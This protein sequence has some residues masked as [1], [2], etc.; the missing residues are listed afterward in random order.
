M[1]VSAKGR[2]YVINP[3]PGFIENFNEISLPGV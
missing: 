1:K 3:K 2:E